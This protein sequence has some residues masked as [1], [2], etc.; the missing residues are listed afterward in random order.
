MLIREMRTEDKP[1]E[2]FAQSPSLASNTDLVAILLRT[3]RQG[4]S[5]MEIAK[6]VVD[7][8]ETTSGIN[9]Y[10]DL[11]WRDLTDIKGIGPDKAITIC[12]AVELGRRLSFLFDRRKLI[13][14]NTPDK[15]ADFF[16]EKLRHEN[17]EHF[18]VSYVNV[19]NRLLGFQEITRGNLNAAPVDIKEAMK[20]GIRYKAYGLILV[21]NHPSG[22][23][24]P[25]KEDI[26]VTKAFAEASKL[27]DMQVLDHVIIGDGTFVSLHERGC[28]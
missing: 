16:M 21:H 5:V 14:F 12:A 22:Y 9:G 17:Q 8:L 2:R 24:E 3:G 4:H 7:M 25:S 11:N 20:W 19:K 13:S 1:R 23:P 27:L 18:M 26:S 6:E 28:L 15:V 10:E